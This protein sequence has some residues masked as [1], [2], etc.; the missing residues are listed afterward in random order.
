[1]LCWLA[2][3]LFSIPYKLDLTVGMRPPGLA[4]TQ[5][6][7]FVLSQRCPAPLGATSSSAP[8][9]GLQLPLLWFKTANSDFGNLSLST[10]S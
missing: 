9:S 8:F 10:V 7:P 4:V 1:M 6:P 2:G 3:V 5:P